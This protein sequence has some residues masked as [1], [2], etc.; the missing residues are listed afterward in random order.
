MEEW[1]VVTVIAV[2]V[3]LMTSVVKPIINLNGSI[4][5][6]TETVNTL[7]KNIAGLAA[8]NSETHEKLWKKNDEQ[9]MRLNQHETRLQ[10]MERRL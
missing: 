7:Q 6:L 9:D 2:L 4:I 3:G 10:I 1:T 5:R 8:K